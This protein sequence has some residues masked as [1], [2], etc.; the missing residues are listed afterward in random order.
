MGVDDGQG[1]E[2]EKVHLEHADILDVMTVILGGPYVEAGF[3]VLGKADGDI[4]R[5]IGRADDCR[6]GVLP[7]LAY[8]SLH[9]AGILQ[10]FAV[11][12]RSVL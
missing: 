4:V 9:L 6:T 5:K 10:H 8:A 2:T 1:V 11:D 7:G 3:L 12:L